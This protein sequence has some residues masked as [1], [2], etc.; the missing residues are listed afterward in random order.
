M[1]VVHC[2]GVRAQFSDGGALDT[3]YELLGGD[4]PDRD[5]WD[6]ESEGG[7]PFVHGDQ[8]GFT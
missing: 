8:Y 6:P 4:G 5:H 1:V 2:H 7:R 3:G